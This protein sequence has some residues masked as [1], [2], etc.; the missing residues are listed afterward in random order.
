[1]L[2]KDAFS[3]SSSKGKSSDYDSEDLNEKK[4]LKRIEEEISHD[5]EAI[6]IGEKKRKFKTISFITTVAGNVSN[7]SMAV[8]ISNGSGEMTPSM[9][10]TFNNNLSTERTM[11]TSDGTR[12]TNGPKTSFSRITEGSQNSTNEVKRSTAGVESSNDIAML[13]FT[14]RNIYTRTPNDSHSRNTTHESIHNVTHQPFKSSASSS[15]FTVPIFLCTLI[16]FILI[17]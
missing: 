2:P 16:T 10:T 17:N 6:R 8:N 15:S 7:K 5:E 13:Q 3:S 12:T 11:S 1:M 9:R 14:D 4:F